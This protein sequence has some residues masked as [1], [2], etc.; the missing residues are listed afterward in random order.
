M[1]QGA[2]WSIK[3]V[4]ADARE[5]AKAKAT[6]AGMTL[7]QWLNKAIADADRPAPPPPPAASGA[8]S[9][10]D[11]AR[12]MRAIAEVA[13]RVDQI[14]P[15]DEAQPAH[16]F[17]SGPLEQRIADLAA[18]VDL[19]AHREPPAPP[20]PPS[21]AP[22]EQR[23]DAIAA[24]LEQLEPLPAAL[25]DLASRPAPE[26]PTPD[27]PPLAPKLEE[28]AQDLRRI[29]NG[30][31]NLG[32]KIDLSEQKVAE[33]LAPLEAR[34]AA[35]EEQSGG[36]EGPDLAAVLAALQRIEAG[37]T[38]TSPEPASAPDPE[39]GPEPVAEE[40]SA[41]A[42]P[43]PEPEPV[44]ATAPEPIPEP[45]APAESL[46][47]LHDLT[48]R[49]DSIAA[50]PTARRE[51]V[52]HDL[53]PLGGAAGPDS[54]DDRPDFGAPPGGPEPEPARQPE[55]EPDR[56]ASFSDPEPV[57]APPAEPGPDLPRD[58]HPAGYDSLAGSEGIPDDALPPDRPR[59][60]VNVESLLEGGDRATAPEADEDEW[61]QV[62]GA[63][64]G[65]PE[66]RLR[67][68]EPARREFQPPPPPREEAPRVRRSRPEPVTAPP[69]RGGYLIAALLILGLLVGGFLVAGSPV[70]DDIASSAGEVIEIVRDS[71]KDDGA[72]TGDATPATTAPTTDASAIAPTMAPGTAASPE[73]APATAPARPAVAETPAAAPAEATTTST[74]QT[75]AA[76]PRAPVAPPPA[77]APSPSP[78]PAP[79]PS[80][81]PAQVPAPAATPVSEIATLRDAATDGDAT[82]QFRLGLR[83]RDGDGVSQSY[84]EAARWFMAAANQGH[85]D[86]QM[87]LGVMYRQ[88][89]G[90]PK[91]IDDARIWLHA[92]AREGHAEAQKYLG[93]VYAQDDQGTPDYFQAA[94]W[95]SEAAQQG[96]VDAQY[97]MGVLY[98][99][100]LGVPR[101]IEQ[102]YYWFGLAARLGDSVAA[103]D[104][105][106][107][108]AQIEAARRAA[109]DGRIAAFQ[110]VR[111]I[112]PGT[113]VREEQATASGGNR[114]E[115]TRRDQIRELQMLLVARGYDPGTPDGLPG[116]RT[117][118]AI[119]RFQSDRGLAVDGR[120][121]ET[122][123][124]Q[125]KSGA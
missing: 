74:P 33:R 98:E 95:F 10:L 72:A 69:R 96:V 36:N 82:A 77:A 104:Q 55:P 97:N 47:A 81:A 48:A 73:P 63:A 31:I 110:P 39:P 59:R 89:V 106:R 44:Q 118:D 7:G 111:A 17:D 71:L 53:P 88:G 28:Q 121:T 45:A 41:V 115:I 103:E 56:F 13:R 112:E 22:L 67:I 75:A 15:S 54:D 23:L 86:A 4:D 84:T 25:H 119:R 24:R 21:L 101:D 52:F 113:I 90:V 35:L 9:A 26:A 66:P 100:G 11:T 12:L 79:A 108:A 70:V 60:L 122:V 65:A 107:L 117:R 58:S 62:P 2:P 57:A 6:A 5:V 3:G 91:S 46:A 38:G 123:L 78:A 99:G 49:R 14:R 40:A 19:L 76:E 32:R 42:P 68:P 80:P 18:S 51:P 30:L 102:A 114:T 61:R 92:A 1:K 109:L 37:R 125:L 116:E 50:S 83:Y 43:G 120:I 8:G 124:Q 16:G 87:N 64:G 20:P 29:M 27:M 93:E 94:R 85:V 34:L 105:S